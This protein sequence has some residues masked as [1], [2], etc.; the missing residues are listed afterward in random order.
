M[1]STPFPEPSPAT[2][3]VG[4]DLLHLLLVPAGIRTGLLCGSRLAV[5]PGDGLVTAACM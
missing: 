1:E 2:R 4:A 3:P 5:R